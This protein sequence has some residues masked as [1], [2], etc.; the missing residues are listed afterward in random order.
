MNRNDEESSSMKISEP[1]EAIENE[2]Y[3]VRYS[4]ETPE[5]AYNSAIYYLTR[6][7]DGPHISLDE[8]QIGLLK[9][10]AVD[11]YTE[12]ILRDLQHAN[13]TKPI[14]RGIARSIINYRRFCM[15]C[16]RQQLEVAG[17]RSLA[18]EALL[19]FLDTEMERLQ[20]ENR[21]SIINCTYTEL[22]SYAALLGVELGERCETLQK[23]CSPSF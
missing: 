1:A 7:K 12:I 13:C 15:F 10:A 9:E 14:Y 8:E 3:I 20:S 16:S 17:V 4:G 21:P 6:A 18:A 5:I 19:E 11:R 23:H 22:K 2:W